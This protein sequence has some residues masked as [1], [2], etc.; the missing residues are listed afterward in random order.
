MRIKYNRF[1]IIP[2]HCT[3]CH[4]YIWLE[5]YRKASIDTGLPI[6]V[7]VKKKICKRCLERYNVK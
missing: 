1:A 2:F 3:D 5:P 7:F 4:N 6:P